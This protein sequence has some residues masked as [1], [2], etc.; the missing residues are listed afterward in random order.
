MHRLSSP[1]HA[2]IALAERSKAH[3]ITHEERS[4]IAIVL[5]I[6][7]AFQMMSLPSCAASSEEER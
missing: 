6:V 2:T 7:R 4:G 1:P 5:F 3:V